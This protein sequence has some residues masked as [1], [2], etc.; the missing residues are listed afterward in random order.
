MVASPLDLV[1][2]Q[3]AEGMIKG[4]SPSVTAALGWTSEDLAGMHWSCLVHPDDRQ[5][6]A[7]WMDLTASGDH[8]DVPASVRFVTKYGGVKWL[9][10]TAHLVEDGA[11]EFASSVVHLDGDDPPPDEDF[12]I[13]SVVM[14]DRQTSLFWLDCLMDPVVILKSLRDDMGTIVDFICVEA[15]EAAC[16]YNHM[17]HD[18][19][20]GSRMLDRLPSLATSGALDAH[21][22]CVESGEPLVLDDL[23]NHHEDLGEDRRYA[24]RGVKFGDGLTLTW[25]DTTDRQKLVSRPELAMR[26]INDVVVLGD[27]EGVITWISESVAHLLGWQPSELIGHRASE[28]AHP[29][30]VASLQ[31]LAPEGERPTTTEVTLRIRCCDES[32]RWIV[33]SASRFTDESSG[34]VLIAGT[35]R[36]AQESTIANIERSRVERQYKLLAENAAGVV[37]R[38]DPHGD[39]EWVSPSIE[40][41]LEFEASE[42]IGTPAL[43]LLVAEDRAA[44]ALAFS[45]LRYGG[46]PTTFE[47]RCRTGAGAVSVLANLTGIRDDD[48]NDAGCIIGLVGIQDLAQERAARVASEERYRLIVENE[49]DLVIRTDL[50]SKVLWVEPSTGELSG[51]GPGDI[52]GQRLTEMVVSEDRLRMA[53]MVSSVV[54]GKSASGRGRLKMT[55]GEERWVAMRAGALFDD[56]GVA[57]GG[58][59]TLRDIDAEVKAEA[60]L[61]ESEQRFR[62]VMESSPIGMVVADLD[63]NFIEVNPRFASMVGREIDWFEGHRVS[64]LIDPSDDVIDLRHRAEILSGRNCSG[65][66]GDPGLTF[67]QLA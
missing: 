4:V 52:I 50:D 61:L 57:V 5:L 19:L 48:G 9:S 33:V 67:E 55:N 13:G 11:G 66:G 38:V 53:I 32:Y 3:D 20:V 60:A 26:H 6:A 29:E 30:D 42:V 58:V 51:W 16:S 10:G 36:D 59:F 23:I 44:A 49:F 14:S 15:N 34:E 12:A 43:E 65:P 35:W 8:S 21:I 47:V 24:L 63:R 17:T 40:R 25:R 45:A 64:E 54:N 22:K 37:I 2:R 18:Q 56:D 7:S 27:S 62:L 39:I 1:F 41:V 28:F 31:A 46:P